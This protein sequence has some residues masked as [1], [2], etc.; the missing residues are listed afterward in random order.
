MGKLK[1]TP[2]PPPGAP[3]G[4]PR[5]RQAF[6]NAERVFWCNTNRGGG[7]GDNSLEQLMHDMHF[8]AAW[9]WGDGTPQAGTFNY[10]EHMQSVQCGDVI[11]MYAN[12]FGVIGIGRAT[13]G[14]L[15]VLEQDDPERMRD[16]ATEGQNAEEWRIPVEWLVWDEDNPCP[17]DSL[18]P[19]FQEITNHPDRIGLIRHHFGA[20]E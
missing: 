13:D 16:Y 19:A 9:T 8:A 20:G 17:V 14:G 1:H 7:A 15:E 6:Q 4:D 11:V 18:R 3:D 12:G 10:P 5:L 2:D